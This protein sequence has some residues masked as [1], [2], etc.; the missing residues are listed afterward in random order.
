MSE[1]KCPSHAWLVR[2]ID[3][4]LTANQESE[5]ASHLEDCSICRET[6]EQLNQ[7]EL[8]DNRQQ[9]SKIIDSQT[10]ESSS[11]EMEKKL[12][13]IRAN[14]PAAD[15]AFDSNY[16]DILS[17]LEKSDQGIGR[18]A[19]FELIRFVGR[20]GMGIVFE[21]NDTKL[22]RTVAIKLMSPGLLA[23]SNAPERFLHEARS[24]AKIN[25]VNVVT[26]H[27]VNQVRGL[28]YLVMEF[29]HGNSLQEQLNAKTRISTN[30]ILKI[31]RQTAL[32][33]A[34]AH[35]NGITHRDIKPS[36]L[37]LD[38]QSKRI[39]IAD[40]GLASTVKDATL[41]RTGMLVGT[42]EFASPE[43]IDGRPVDARSDLFSLGCVLFTLCTG[44]PP[45]AS[46]SL[47]K[48]LDATRL[49]D[50]DF[51]MLHSRGIPRRLVEIIRR[52]VEKEPENRFQS[53][54]QLCDALKQVSTE[55]SCIVTPVVNEPSSQ[56]PEFQG[57]LRHATPAVYVAVGMI[58]FLATVI[59]PVMWMQPWKSIANE[60]GTNSSPLSEKQRQ[61]DMQF[62]QDPNAENELENLLTIRVESSEELY[63]ALEQ[64]GDLILE[65]VPGKI[66][67]VDEPLELESRIVHFH[68]DPQYMPILDFGGQNEDVMI[69][70]EDGQ[71]L[72][73]GVNLRDEIEMETQES[74]IVCEDGILQL[75]NCILT[76]S[77]RERVLLVSESDLVLKSSVLVSRNT[78]LEMAAS[79][80]KS[81]RVLE[82]E[83]VSS[84]NFLIVGPIEFE[85]VANN[86]S[87]SA[88]SGFEIETDDLHGVSFE[89]HVEGCEFNYP[90][91]MLFIDDFSED[92]NEEELRFQA[93]E[94]LDWIV[95][96]FRMKNTESY[97]PETVVQFG[98]DD[99][100][101]WEQA[102][103]RLGQK[104]QRNVAEN[105]IERLID[106]LLENEFKTVDQFR[107]MRK[108]GF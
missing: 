80:D 73:N 67:R 35:A 43:Q 105:D 79:T 49:A 72:F 38:R 95:E 102:K 52:L 24:A 22:E 1:K 107:E 74:L 87:F 94:V 65:L 16:A 60:A 59:G 85:L 78:C 106:R 61:R 66:Y 26:V 25:H 39:R 10:I 12:A 101:S 93:A 21:A 69:H 31:I 7:S 56:T 88:S 53:A 81:V 89:F 36:N 14:R 5:L 76:S 2:L 23:D 30:Q 75:E 103:I 45:F 50:P 41:T 47:V 91:A 108:I 55:D 92:E 70:S 51:N 83:V 6:L 54:Q 100:I 34:A 18:I 28:P 99:Y 58:L 8:L 37:V 71:L 4:K 97:V 84:N 68:G 42:P 90:E 27:A 19:E 29:V 48:T 98:D 77:H 96:S 82:S 63:E 64:P 57:K 15:L 40:F 104:A 86:S 3:G 20:G 9:P 62:G 32:G 46:E 44:N 17:W 33:L 13:Q 11:V